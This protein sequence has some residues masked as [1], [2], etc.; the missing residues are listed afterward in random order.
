MAAGRVLNYT[1]ARR[2][3]KS[4][5]DTVIDDRIAIT[6]TRPTSEPVVMMA[7]TEYDALLETLYLIRSPR[8]AA[9]LREANAEI[10]K[11][12]V[13]GVQMVDGEVRERLEHR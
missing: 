1:Q 12:D 8:N 10:D 13:I 2:N 5:M 9:R 7:K 3:L 11:G 6:I 4:L